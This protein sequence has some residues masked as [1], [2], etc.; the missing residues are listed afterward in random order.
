MVTK[1]RGVPGLDP[2]IAP[3]VDALMDYGVETFE[4]CEGTEGHSYREPTVRFHGQPEEGFRAYAAAMERG[5]PVSAVR[6]VWIVV[7]GELTG[8]YW[9]MTFHSRGRSLSGD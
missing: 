8:P 6:R 5:L 2:G 9:E 3:M 1:Q 4:S 7:D